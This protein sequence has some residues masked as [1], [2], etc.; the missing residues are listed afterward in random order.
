MPKDQRNVFREN[1]SKLVQSLNL[2]KLSPEQKKFI[3][4]AM[5]FS[6]SAAYC[7][8][9]HDMSGESFAAI[10]YEDSYKKIVDKIKKS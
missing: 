10:K 2:E 4:T 8:R 1:E 9:T 5:K 3:L 6:Y 7:S